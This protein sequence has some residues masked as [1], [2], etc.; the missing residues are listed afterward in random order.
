MATPGGVTEVMP[1]FTVRPPMV[2]S[3]KA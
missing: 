3:T 1:I 2:R